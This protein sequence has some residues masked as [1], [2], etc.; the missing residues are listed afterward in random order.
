MRP[1]TQASRP[2]L[3]SLP[4]A[5]LW[6]G[7]LLAVFAIFLVRLFYLQV[8]RHDYYQKAA[9]TTQLKEYIIPAPRGAIDAHDGDSVIPIV[10]NETLYTLFADPKF[11]SDPAA[12]ARAAAEV[13]GG[14][15]NDYEQKMQADSRYAILAKKLSKEQKTKLDAL[16][17]KGVGTRE[18]QHRTYPQG[19]LAAQVLGFVNDEG[20]G[21]YGIE[22]FLDDRLSGTPGQLKA[23]TDAAGVPLVANQ[24]NVNIEPEAGARVL[25]TVDIS[26]QR[27]LEEILKQG[28]AAA[29]SDSGSALILDPETGAIKAMANYPTYSPA[30]FSKV[31]DPAVFNNPVVS[32]P[33]EVGSIMKPLTVAAGLDV[34]AISPD[35][36]YYD[37]GFVVVDG[38]R[39]TN[40]EEVGGSG[41][42]SITDIL[43]MSLNTGATFVLKAMGGGEVNEQARTTW[44]SYMTD[45]YRLGRPTGV[46]QGFEAEGSIPDPHEGFGLG[47]QYANTAFGQGMTATPMQMAAAF[48]AVVNGGTYYRPQLVDQL[49]DAG[50][51]VTDKAPEVLQHNVVSEQ[52]GATI[53]DMLVYAV[54]EN[55]P[56]AVREGY[57]VGGKTGT[58][59]IA[60]P[61]GGYYS[62]RYNGMYMGFVGGDRAEYVIVVR[63]NQPR[64][65]GYAGSQAAQPIFTSLSNMLIDNFGIT[66][67][68]P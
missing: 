5:R 54:G 33:L 12:A 64:K 60:R 55:N 19:S 17:L 32:S 7:L 22:Q 51:A 28:V 26:M 41:T 13:T 61:E 52:V 44:H 45:H 18:E 23:I 63:V 46:E 27:Q 42:R 3:S 14:N 15:A 62:D 53:R 57:N 67:K 43:Q 31:E 59:Q 38:A 40:V 47:I 24:D 39:I 1:R 50:G 49:T 11:I 48:A 34:G 4:R 10:L 56:P 30:E 36:S 37:P 21:T 6:Y 25:L 58:A 16:E 8:I 35:T 2:A 29:Q 68:T 9:Q 20:T 65:P 66:P